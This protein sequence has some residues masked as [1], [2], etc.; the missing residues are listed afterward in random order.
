MAMTTNIAGRSPVVALTTERRWA[1]F[2]LITRLV[3]GYQWLTS[4]W[5]KLHDPTWV[6]DQA[7]AAMTGFVHNALTLAG[8]AHP[9]VQSWYAWFLQ[10]LVLP[11]ATAW[12]Y[13]IAFG[14][15]L[16]G[17]GLITGTL[18][19]L[20]AFFGGFMDLNYL[21]SG[22]VS[23][24]PILLIAAIGLALAWRIAGWWGG[25]RWLLPA[26]DRVRIRR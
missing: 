20:A 7:G 8:G 14:E 25:D 15:L 6:G 5:G 9:N 1:W 18:T 3:V 26:L 2:W 11:Q 24:N 23:I 10:N 21:L 4:G 22:S 13:A 16:V 12:G 19:G 17:L